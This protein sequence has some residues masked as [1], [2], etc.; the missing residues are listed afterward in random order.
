MEM[1]KSLILAAILTLALGVF[2]PA[3]ARSQGAEE[4][5]VVVY[6]DGASLA[7]AHTAIRLAGAAVVRENAAVGVTTVATRNVNFVRD[8]LAQ[9]AFVG[10][11]RK[12]PLGSTPTLVPKAD[13]VAEASRTAA[14][15]MAAAAVGAE[16]LAGLQWGMAM[17]H[18]TA[19]G[20]YAVEPGKPGVKV[21]IIDSGIDASHPDIAPNFDA[22]L[23]KTFAT[24]IPLIDGPCEV[25]SCVDPPNV[26]DNG[27]GTHVAGIVGAALNG[28]GVA[29]VAPNVTL[30]N[31]RAG[32]DSGYVF[33]QPVVDALT[34]AGNNG[35]DV[36]NMS[37]YI[38][39]WLFNCADNPADSP[40]QQAEQRAI[41]TA[42]QRALKYA[43]NHN[44]TM[45]NSL[46]NSHIDLDNPT[47]DG[48]SPDYPPGSEY[49][50]TIDNSCLSLPAEGTHIIGVS[51][52]G[53]ST[54]KADYSNWRGEEQIVSAPGGWF[55][56]FFGTPQFRT[57]ENLIL[58][59]YPE[60]LGRLT[61]RIAP[62]GS[63]VD[64]AVVRDCQGSVCAYYQYLQ[65]TSMA[66][67][68]A[69]GVAALIVSDRGKADNKFG[70]L[71][72][73]PSSVRQV[74]FKTATDHAC[75]NPPVIDYLD[76]GRD[77]SWTATCIGNAKKNNIYGQGIVDAL[78]AVQ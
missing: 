26:D 28:L 70:G 34:Y 46:G 63:V 20:S 25:A 23:S 13:E 33:L 53:P 78:R 54:A 4:Q 57:N 11:A 19:S 75:P 45:V 71:K 58:S 60:A 40:E 17:I 52:L 5:Y 30:V 2:A 69:T 27:H 65:G 24:D 39:P 72:M 47:F 9:G 31:L 68:H 42:V 8:A 61:G 48:T 15:P 44:V 18:A 3:T 12:A 16:P 21:G 64:P 77:A 49:P 10:V 50:R 1:R 29:G 74:L 38:D 7:T 66:A 22:T 14:A 56:D 37:F 55:R 76:E 6:R 51:A 32:Q 41:V 62:D 59:T 35:I 43:H 36:V 73:G 67:P